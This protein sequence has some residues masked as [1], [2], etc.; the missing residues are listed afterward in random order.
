MVLIKDS[1]HALEW[2]VLDQARVKNMH[3]PLDLICHCLLSCAQFAGHGYSWQLTPSLFSSL[4]CYP[5]IHHAKHK[6]QRGYKGHART[7]YK[8]QEYLSVNSEMVS[9]EEARLLWDTDGYHR[10]KINHAKNKRQQNTKHK[11]NRTTKTARR[12]G[13]VWTPRFFATTN[14]KENNNNAT[15]RNSYPSIRACLFVRESAP[16]CKD[17]KKRIKKGMKERKENSG[18]LDLPFSPSSYL[19]FVCD[20]RVCKNNLYPCLMPSCVCE[21]KKRWSIASS[22][23]FLLPRATLQFYPH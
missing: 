11:R 19:Y 17:R 8:I 21:K 16:W 6:T 7:A 18:D 12:D 9:E 14:S 5:P 15:M 20:W 22:H 13:F 23:I 1:S 2:R 4:P 3:T 10:P